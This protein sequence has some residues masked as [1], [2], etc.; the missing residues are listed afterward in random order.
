MGPPYSG[1]YYDSAETGTGTTT[2]KTKAGASPTTAS[3]GTGTTTPGTK[4]GT[5]PTTASTGTGPATTTTKTGTSPTTKNGTTA[6][7]TSSGASAGAKAS[8]TC[9]DVAT[10]DGD[11]C[12][13]EMDVD[14]NK[15]Y[16]YYY[17]FWAFM[18]LGSF[19]L[20]RYSKKTDSKTTDSK[21][22][23]SE[24]KNGFVPCEFATDSRKRFHT[25]KDCAYL[26]GVDY[27]NVKVCQACLDHRAS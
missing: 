12:E 25:N 9:H 24:V 27:K 14:E 15:A 10:G 2:T 4:A 8:G 5:S 23:A 6:T 18:L 7:T 17:N 21:E 3:T 26:N 20:G 16:N 11:Y 1:D 19:C 13:E 22:T